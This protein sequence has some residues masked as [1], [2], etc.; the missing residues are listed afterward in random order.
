M[1]EWN[2]RTLWPVLKMGGSLDSAGS[3]MGDYS[4]VYWLNSLYSNGDEIKEWK[5]IYQRKAYI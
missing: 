4:N 2:K 3:Y 5:L 1:S